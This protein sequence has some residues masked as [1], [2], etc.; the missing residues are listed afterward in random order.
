MDVWNIEKYSNKWLIELHTKVK[1]QKCPF[2]K[3][4][5][6]RIYSYRK[7]SI[8]GPILSN[9]P[10][11]IIVKKRRYLCTYCPHTFYER[12]Q[13]VDIYQRCTNSVQTSALTYSAVG[14]FTLVARLT[15]I[16]TNRLIRLFD[17]HQLFYVPI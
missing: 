9:T 16:S 12:L 11:K 1:K 14:F 15:G 5:T 10:V 8:Q 13:M 3:E 2:C 4:R 7:Q 17:R 6:K